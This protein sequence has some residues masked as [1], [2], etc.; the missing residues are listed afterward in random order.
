MPSISFEGLK[1]LFLL[2]GE[3]SCC[4]NSP[5]PN[6]FSS[7]VHSITDITELRPDV[8]LLVE[9]IACS[10]VLDD[11]FDFGV[12]GNGELAWRFSG[13]GE[14]KLHNEEL[15]FDDAEACL[16]CIWARNVSTG[17][18][19][20]VLFVLCS[21]LVRMGPI[22]VFVECCDDNDIFPWSVDNSEQF[23]CMP[24]IVDVDDANVNVLALLISTETIMEFG[25]C[26]GCIWAYVSEPLV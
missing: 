5:E 26:I 6:S 16:E 10:C 22:T 25:E 20:G 24:V 8:K 4:N 11:R 18:G 21:K 23:G 7:P 17:G 19:I 1:L 2:C 15:L 12:G 14:P 9:L 13:F 3:P